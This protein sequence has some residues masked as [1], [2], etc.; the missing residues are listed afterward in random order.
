MNISE[1]M[2]KKIIFEVLQEMGGGEQPGTGQEED[3][4]ALQFSEVDQNHYRYSAPR[5]P[6]RIDGRC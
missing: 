4:P 3:I 5:G 1:E 2:V 6:E